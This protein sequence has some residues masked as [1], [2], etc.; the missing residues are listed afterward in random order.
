MRRSS[1]GSGPCCRWIIATTSIS[2]RPTQRSIPSCS[3]ARPILEG[4]AY[5]KFDFRFTPDFG[6]TQNNGTTT[7]STPQ[8]YDAYIDA[9]LYPEFKIRVGKF[10]PPLGLER[11]QSP[12]DL[13][14][15]ERAFPT[16]LV[17]NRDIGLQFSGDLFNRT[18]YYAAGVFNGA[19]DNALAQTGDANNGKDFNLRL[20]AQ[21]WRNTDLTAL[22]GLGVGIAYGR[23]VQQGVAVTNSQLPTYVTPGQENF[24]TYAANAVANGERVTWAPQLYYSVGPFGVLGEYTN[25]AQFVTRSTNTQNVSNNAWQVALTWVLTGEKASF[26]GV[27]PSERFNLSKAHWGDLQLVAR[28]SKLTVDSNAYIGTAATQLANPSTQASK[29]TDYGIGLGWDLSREVRIMLDYDQTTFK[30]GAANGGDRPD[31]KVIITRFQYAL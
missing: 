28:V 5:E 3:A 7:A 15:A 10:K 19:V 22:R 18:L 8:I 11:L 27:I 4:T 9:N 16:D 24:F 6:N 14:F 21:P 23:G 26:Y 25:T 12:A 30:G 2:S 1:S 31:E 13:L 29:A 20:F 17:P